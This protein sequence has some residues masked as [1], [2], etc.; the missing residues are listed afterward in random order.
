MALLS[1]PRLLNGLV[2][3]LVRPVDAVVNGVTRVLDG[4]VLGTTA[5]V[6]EATSTATELATG[7]P[8]PDEATSPKAVAAGLAG[9]LTT[10]ATWAWE[11]FTGKPL[12]GLVKI[13][14][15]ALA[16]FLGSYTAS[17]PRRT[18]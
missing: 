8:T 7:E 15:G 17:D 13:L 3:P 18:S 16:A 14:L 2:A 1:I 9:A 4:L 6:R 10:V 12:P 11:R 5:T